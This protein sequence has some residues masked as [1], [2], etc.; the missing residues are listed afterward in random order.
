MVI[1]TPTGAVTM[2]VFSAHWCAHC[3]KHMP[4]VKRVW[5]D[6]AERS[7]DTPRPPAADRPQGGRRAAPEAASQGQGVPL[8][9]VNTAGGNGVG[10]A[11][12]VERWGLLRAAPAGNTSESGSQT[13]PTALVGVDR[14]FRA[15]R[16]YGVKA[17]PVVFL[18]GPDGTIEAVHGR[19]ANTAVNNGLDNLEAE[20]RAELDVLLRSGTRTDFPRN[21][22]ARDGRPVRTAA[23]E[24]GVTTR[25]TS[26]R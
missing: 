12:A 4:V 8:I 9:A 23:R 2:L 21:R 22:P 5:D 13:P 7:L 25:P 26:L 10:I 18:I 14:G 19:H 16:Q 24:V 20:L 15:V 3:D 6:Y 17:Y 1:G 11:M